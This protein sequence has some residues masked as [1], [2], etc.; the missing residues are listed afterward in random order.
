MFFISHRKNENMKM[1]TC[2]STTI[3]LK[4]IPIVVFNTAAQKN[5]NWLINYNKQ[6]F[7]KSWLF[8]YIHTVCIGFE[9]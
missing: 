5:L 1:V 6:V 3:H 2:S 9:N 7:I 4:L 8:N